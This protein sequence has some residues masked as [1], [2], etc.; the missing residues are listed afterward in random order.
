[1]CL[2]VSSPIL[3]EIDLSLPL[4]TN[5]NLQ[6]LIQNLQ[7]DSWLEVQLC[8]FERL[9]QTARPA[10][11]SH[12]RQYVLLYHQVTSPVS[13]TTSIFCSSRKSDDCDRLYDILPKWHVTRITSYMQN[14]IYGQIHI[15]LSQKPW[16]YL[17]FLLLFSATVVMFYIAV[18]HWK[19]W[20][21]LMCLIV[22]CFWIC[23][24]SNWQSSGHKAV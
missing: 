11:D 23:R 6:F 5:R 12:W 3:S 8:H 2:C 9:L 18:R 20:Y 16:L 24:N 19:D 10:I 22:L 21:M 4:K 17:H 7:S 15:H 14:M 1:V 13:L